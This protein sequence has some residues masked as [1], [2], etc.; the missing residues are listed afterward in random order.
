MS[1]FIKVTREKVRKPP[2]PQG[3]GGE[4]RE[5][6]GSGELGRAGDREG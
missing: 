5:G 2:L 1:L 6:E 3:G 4:D